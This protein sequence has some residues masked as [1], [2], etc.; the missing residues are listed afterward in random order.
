MNVGRNGPQSRASSGREQTIEAKRR[1]TRNGGTS[2]EKSIIITDYAVYR[3]ICGAT[4]T[5]FATGERAVRIFF[6]L[7]CCF[8]CFCRSHVVVV[9]TTGGDRDELQKRVRELEEASET[10][11]RRRREAAA[12]V[13]SA[14]HE[15]EQA[16]EERAIVAIELEAALERDSVTIQRLRDQLRDTQA[17]LAL[18]RRADPSAAAAPSPATTTATAT[19]A[20][21]NTTNVT[22]SASPPNELRT[23]LAQ[24]MLATI[25]SLQ[26]LLKS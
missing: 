23:K 13:T 2:Y 4:A 11:E 17:E 15:A 22:S 3:T 5:S 19:T 26:Q 20:A 25:R 10:L 7:I 8:F 16:A 21:A 12:S 24:D 6:L 14:T 18:L 9:V 1:T